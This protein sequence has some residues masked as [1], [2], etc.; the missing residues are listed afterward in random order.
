MS[1]LKP[2]PTPLSQ[3]WIRFRL[4]IVPI[5]AFLAMSFLSFMLMQRHAG[6]S[7]FVGEVGVTTYKITA[8][9]D[10]LVTGSELQSFQPVSPQT[11]LLAINPAVDPELVGL[12]SKLFQ[13]RK[14]EL[15]KQLD[16]L[17]TSTLNSNSERLLSHEVE[18]RRLAVSYASFR[19]DV[20][21][22]TT[23]LETAR[24]ELQL[25]SEQMTL[26]KNL[27]EAGGE[28]PFQLR[29]AEIREETLRKQVEQGQLALTEAINQRDDALIRINEQTAPI[30]ADIEAVMA[31]ITQELESVE[32]ELQVYRKET[33]PQPVISPVP[34]KISMIYY[35]SGEYVKAGDIIAEVIVAN[36][37]H[38][39]TYIRDPQA[40]KPAPGKNVSIL[41]RS[42]P[43]Q[44]FSVKIT[45][46]GPAV[47][48]VPPHHLRDRKLREQGLPVKIAMPNLGPD[49]ILQPGS[50]V[51]IIFR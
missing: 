48:E 30:L 29:L 32:I 16:A 27:V 22:R 18:A 20:L 47:V 13:S 9:I 23:T 44:E 24:A 6:V 11:P 41:V 15:L 51:D 10:G 5:L 14:V 39:V 19:I 25:L 31:P 36:S 50:L 35:R 26:L 4:Q 34:G 37:D 21:D 38:I 12:E 46:I 42:S 45:E 2:I 40:I 28:N 43:P 33:T 17:K 1:N 7:D 49:T 8:P 3:R